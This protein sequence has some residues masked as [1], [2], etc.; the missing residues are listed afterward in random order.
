MTKQDVGF[1]A[2]EVY[3]LLSQRGKLSLRKLGELTHQR[4]SVIFLSSGWLLRE[5]K[6]NVS[7]QNGE[8]FF[9]I[10]TA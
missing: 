8:Y 3:T 6:I 1:N 10:Q 4:E 9:E 2:G 7:K 5:N